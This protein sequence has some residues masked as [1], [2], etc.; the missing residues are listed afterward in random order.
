MHKTWATIKF[1]IHSLRL[2]FN[3]PSILHSFRIRQ[4]FLIFIQTKRQLNLITCLRKFIQ[5]TCFNMHIIRRDK[6]LLM[7]VI[8]IQMSWWEDKALVGWRLRKKWGKILLR[9]PLCLKGMARWQKETSLINHIKI[10]IEWQRKCK[11]AISSE[12]MCKTFWN[13]HWVIRDIP[14]QQFKGIM[15][16][17][18][19]KIIEIMHLMGRQRG[20]IQ[21]IEKEYCRIHSFVDQLQHTSIDSIFFHFNPK[22][23]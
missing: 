2:W 18:E 16:I 21:K 1:L 9:I 12:R 7:I 13:T 20:Q 6:I 11:Q 23:L 8:R 17:E 19:S 4:T 10:S 3:S 15:K 14:L 22:I 5:W